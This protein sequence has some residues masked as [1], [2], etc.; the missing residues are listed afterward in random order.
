MQTGGRGNNLFPSR[1]HFLSFSAYLGLDHF[2]PFHM[3]EMTIYILLFSM[4]DDL[5]CFG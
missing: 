2:I 5:E 4:L 1:F 3:S